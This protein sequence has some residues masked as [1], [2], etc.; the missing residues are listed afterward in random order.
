ML[1]NSKLKQWLILLLIIVAII[2]L[3]FFFFKGVNKPIISGEPNIT[4]NEC[5]SKDGEIVNTLGGKGCKSQ[6]AFL[7]TVKGMDCPCVCCKK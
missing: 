3:I 2:V 5:S 7:G 4:S 6:E 1:I